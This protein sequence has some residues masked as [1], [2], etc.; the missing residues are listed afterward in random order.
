M[1][2]KSN[3]TAFTSSYFTFSKLWIILFNLVVCVHGQSIDTSSLHLNIKGNAYIYSESSDSTA[4]ADS[5]N[6]IID[7]KI[8]I[9]KGVLVTGIENLN[10]SITLVYIDSKD[11]QDDLEETK[12]VKE[13]QTAPTATEHISKPEQ[14]Q[15]RKVHILASRNSS[16]HLLM[17]NTIN[18]FLVLPT[19]YAAKGINQPQK[20]INNF[21]LLPENKVPCTNSVRMTSDF[22]SICFTLRGP[23]FYA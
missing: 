3:F 16:E 1:N 15:S 14:P 13:D 22:Y 9:S 5:V 4:K 19:T 12:W 2:I 23:P 10:K 11:S 20:Q 18:S 17:G 21:L 7:S 6:E 8:Y